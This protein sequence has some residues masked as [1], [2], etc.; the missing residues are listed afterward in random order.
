[1]VNLHNL[2]GSLVYLDD[3]PRAYGAFQQSLALCEESS[4]ERLA[5]YN[6]M[7]LA[8]LDGLQGTADG[9]KLLGQGIAY[10]ASK[11]FTWDVIGGRALLAKLLHRRGQP[12]AAR[13]AY[14]VARALASSAGHTLIADDCDR[15]LAS[16]R[17]S[18]ARS[19]SAS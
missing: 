18:A 13:E 8:F 12:D 16:L 11:D 1:M 14:E 2:G 5:N 3:L 4:Y 19:A 7:F 10:A 9:E 15:A 17:G 6:R